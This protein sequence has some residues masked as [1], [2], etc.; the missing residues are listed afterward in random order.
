MTVCFVISPYLYGVFFYFFLEV[1]P[2]YYFGL[3]EISSYLKVILKPSRF[4]SIL[5]YQE[6]IFKKKNKEIAFQCICQKAILS[7]GKEFS[8]WAEDKEIKDCLFYLKI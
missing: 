8:L 5:Q 6:S 2:I 1:F 7:G 4:G 3:K